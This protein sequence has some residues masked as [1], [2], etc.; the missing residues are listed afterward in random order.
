MTTIRRL[1][2][3]KGFTVAELM[4]SLV[5]LAAVVG[6]STATLLK[7]QKQYTT[8][9]ATTETRETLRAVEM[10]VQR[11]FRNA[12]VNPRNVACCTLAMAV[13][14]LGRAATNGGIFD[15][16]DIRGD[17]NPIDGLAKGDWEDVRI[18]R[19]NDTV[20]VRYKLAA[21]VNKEPVA[22]PVSQLRFQFYDLA[23][24]ELTTAGAAAAAR[25]VRVT[26]AAPVPNTS[27]TLKRELWIFLRN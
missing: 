22:Y 24:N 6:A 4:V 27:A 2:L 18:E 9:R 17:F 20:Y 1:P 16:V 13:D 19:T 10:V 14:P 21:G 23:R 11:A 26:M 25:S 5:V 3:R 12:R 7:V 15:M 8:Q